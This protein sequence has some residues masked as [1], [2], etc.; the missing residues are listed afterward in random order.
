M[1]V[2]SWEQKVIWG[3]NLEAERG[4][5]QIIKGQEKADNPVM[6]WKSKKGRVLRTG[7][8]YGQIPQRGQA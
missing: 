4:S 7:V 5:T 2:N 6:F 3:Q 1:W 8:K